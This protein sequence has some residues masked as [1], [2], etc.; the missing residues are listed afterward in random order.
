VIGQLLSRLRRETRGY[1][2]VEMVVVMALLGIVT[3]SLTTIFVSASSAEVS[4][5]RR[6]EA[7]QQARLALDRI[8]GDVHCASKAQAQTINT[9]TGVKLD[10]TSC[11]AGTATTVSWCAVPVTASPPRYALY[12]TT[13]TTNVCTASDTSRVLVSDYLMTTTNLFTTANTPQY[14]LQAV[15]LDFRV[16]IAGTGNDSYELTDAIVVRNSTRC[17][18]ASPGCPAPTVP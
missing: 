6:F 11:Y 8:R 3:S 7:Q 9:Y 13:G 2:L 16:S 5:N 15:G 17:A 12:R 1:T 14:A 4:L 10:V 18:T